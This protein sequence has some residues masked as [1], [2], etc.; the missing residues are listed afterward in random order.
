MLNQIHSE[1]LQNILSNLTP[2]PTDIP[3]LSDVNLNKIGGNAADWISS[4]NA[5][6]IAS[7][8]KIAG[9]VE[10]ENMYEAL[11]DLYE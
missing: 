2:T 6:P 11:A 7:T 4:N 1:N 9:L 5:T 3:N 10:H 8:S